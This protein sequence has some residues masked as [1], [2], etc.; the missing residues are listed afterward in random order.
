[1]WL[2]LQN[3]ALLTIVL[4]IRCLYNLEKLSL[5]EKNSYGHRNVL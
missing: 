5:H 2:N 3:A 1:M 4:V